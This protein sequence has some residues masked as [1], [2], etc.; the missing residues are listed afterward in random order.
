MLGSL[1]G[2]PFH[3]RWHRSCS[4]LAQQRRKAEEA[5]LALKAEVIDSLDL[6][7]KIANCR[8]GYMSPTSIHAVATGQTG[9]ADPATR[10]F[11]SATP[12]QG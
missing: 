4:L 3:G 11:R 10:G 5:L 1:A 9:A 7:E 8:S 12:V 6:T 2:L